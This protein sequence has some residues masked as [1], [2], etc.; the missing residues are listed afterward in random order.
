MAGPLAAL[1][2]PI[3]I[4]LAV[5]IVGFIFFVYLMLRRTLLGLREGYDQGRER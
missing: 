4:G 3:F 5:L 1:D 2:D